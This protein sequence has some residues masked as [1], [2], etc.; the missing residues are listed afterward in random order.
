MLKKLTHVYLRLCI[1][2]ETSD[3]L[4]DNKSQRVAQQATA[5]SND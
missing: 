2:R 4:G 1:N 3:T 5:N